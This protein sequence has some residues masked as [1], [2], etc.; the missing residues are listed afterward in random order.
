MCS[1]YFLH[2]LC[3]LVIVFCMFF[4]IFFLLSSFNVIFV[5][6]HTL[7]SH[8]SHASFSFSRIYNGIFTNPYTIIWYLP[9]VFWLPSPTKFL[10][11]IKPSLLLPFFIFLG[12]HMQLCCLTNAHIVRFSPAFQSTGASVSF[13]SGQ[14]KKKK[15]RC[16]ILRISATFSIISSSFIV[17]P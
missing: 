2:M 7:Y 11:T 6:V 10:N 17:K 1:F 12:K 16:A 15:K 4:I 5:Y 8:S 9:A 3:A 13:I 14:R